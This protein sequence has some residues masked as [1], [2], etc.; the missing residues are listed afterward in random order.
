[1]KHSMDPIDRL[2]H[3]SVPEPNSGCYLWVGPTVVAG[4]GCLQVHGKKYRAHRL[5]WE[6]L[7]GS[8]PSGFDVL[9]RCDVPACVNPDHL[10]LGTPKTNR[11]DCAAKDRTTWGEKHGKAK[12][13]TQQVLAIRADPRST[14]MIAADYG[15][16]HRGVGRIKRGEMRRRG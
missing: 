5:A 9:H 10:F 7:K 4:Y 6:L 13:S 11:Q 14:R 2:E 1:M 16:D 3:Y 15:I 8:I 12:L